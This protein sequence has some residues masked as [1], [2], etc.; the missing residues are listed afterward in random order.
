MSNQSE[1]A[2]E[3]LKSARAPRW[4]GLLGFGIILIAFGASVINALLSEP[5]TF[6]GRILMPLIFVGLASLLYHIGQHVHALHAN[7]LRMIAMDQDPSE[8]QPEHSMG[9]SGHSS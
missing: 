7:A 4:L 3:L 9:Q 2:A 8:K 6:I 5:N 1:R